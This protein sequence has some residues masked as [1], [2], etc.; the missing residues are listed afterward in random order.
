MSKSVSAKSK[1]GSKSVSKKENTSSV[2][3]TMTAEERFKK[4]SDRKHVLQRPPTYIGSVEPETKPMW[5]IN[6]DH[7]RDESKPLIICK[8]ITFTPGL[9]KIYDEIL[10]NARDHIIRCEEENY[11]RCTQIKVTIDRDSQRITVWNNGAGIPVEIHSKHKMYIPTMI[12]SQ[13]KTSENYND[14]KKRTIGGMNGFGAKLT[15]IFSK[16]FTIE[17]LDTNTG[18]KFTQTFK[19]NMSVICEPKIKSNSNKHGYTSVSFVPD[20]PKFGLDEFTDDIADLFT[21]RVYDIAMTTSAKVYLNDKLITVNSFVKYVDSYFPTG[22]NYEKVLDVSNDRWKVCVVYD[23]SSKMDHQNISFV[24]GVC[25]YRGGT[26]VDYVANQI[27]KELHTAIIKKVKTI[28]IK[29]SMIKENLIFFIDS[30]ID[31]PMFDTQTKE[32]L[33][34]QSKKFGSVYQVSPKFIAKIIKTGVV[35]QIIANAQAKEEAQLTKSGRGRK[36]NHAKHYEAHRCKLKKGDCRLILTEG[37]SAKGFAMAGLNKIG[38][39]YY[40]V[41][42]LKGKLLNARKAS[43]T[44]ISE[45]K[46]IEAIV[47][48][49]GLEYKKEYTSTK[50]LYYGSIIILTD[51]DVDGSHIKGLIM[52]FIHFFWPSLAKLE[53]FITSFSTPLIKAYKGKNKNKATCFYTDIEYKNWLKDNNDGKGWTIKYYKGLGTSTSEEAKECMTDIEDK[54]NYYIWKNKKSKS[55]KSDKS[56]KSEK[57][58]KSE[59]NIDECADALTLVFDNKREDDRKK[60]IQTYNPDNFI[61]YSVQ[62]ILYSDFINIEMIAFS[63][64]S[65]NRAIPSVIDGFKPCQRKVYYGCIIKKD[66]N[67]YSNEIKVAQLV[68]HIS[69][70]TA[71]HHGEQSLCDTIVKMAQNF[72]GSNNINLLV[73]AGQFGTRLIGGHDAASPRYIF[74]QLEEISRKIFIDDDREVLL[75]QFDDTMEIEPQFFVPIIPMILV[76]GTEGIATGY[77]TNVPQFNPRD[78]INNIKRVLQGE[79]VKTMRPWYRNFTGTIERADDKSYYSRA[80]Y[81]IDGDNVHITDLPI[82][83]WTDDYKASLLE[84]TDKQIVNNK[85]AAKK[86][87]A[88]SV[89]KNN[90][91]TRA[92]AKSATKV[93]VKKVSPISKDIIEW[94]ENCTDSR[95]DIMI[96]FAPNTLQKYLEPFDENITKLEKYLKLTS[97]RGL[98]MNNIHLIN[99]NQIIKKYDSPGQI[100]SEFCDIRLSTYQQRKEYLLKKW[101]NDLDIRYWKLKF[102]NAIINKEIVIHN[103]TKNQ[104]DELLKENG[105]PKLAIDVKTI[106]KSFDYLTSIP[107][108]RLTKDE[109]KKLKKEIQDREDEIK[110]LDDKSPSDIWNE[111]LDELLE[112]YEKWETEDRNRNIDDDEKKPRKKKKQQK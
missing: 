66:P 101:R 4:L 108:V 58:E 62:K 111:E 17:T 91:K 18:K 69:E 33:T 85:P 52:N 11:E 109:I 55:D 60:W 49:V 97:S 36:F 95:I 7:E 78:I 81:E 6:P 13:M 59:K 28:K 50:G 67:L 27:V 65:I 22:G 16:E 43:P 38:R 64:Y 70:K 48:L 20:L 23:R 1:T 71:Y 37:D 107:I 75:K 51:Q 21:K 102:L 103:M 44:K 57:T 112:T 2:T 86:S 12:F 26:H 98:N 84:I 106:K 8:D 99:S 79:K 35:D 40:G 14:D 61:D 87:G 90:A 68:G 25:T 89:T 77:S 74:T 53:G 47:K 19:D 83:T 93:D 104:V 31:N 94:S 73:P 72:V 29:P 54:L 45:N 100:L 82:G 3:G 110:T 76:N 10:V 39:D 46:E 30:T 9:Y 96:T 63:A 56:D 88:K 5:I 15:N 24:N 32:A 80:K 41:F 42:P 105:Y 92:K 34:T